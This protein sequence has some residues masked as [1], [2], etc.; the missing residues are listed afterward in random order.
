LLRISKV[1]DWTSTNTK[2]GS[3]LRCTFLHGTVATP[4]PS[5]WHYAAPWLR[6]RGRKVLT[7]KVRAR[8]QRALVGVDVGTRGRWLRRGNEAARCSGVATSWGDAAARPTMVARRPGH[9]LTGSTVEDWLRQLEGWRDVA[10]QRRGGGW[11]V[12]GCV[13]QR[14]NDHPAA[15]ACSAPGGMVPEP[16]QRQRHGGCCLAGVG[17][18]P[19]HRRLERKSITPHVIETLIK[20]INK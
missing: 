20:V 18:W 6:K 17:A 4:W 2:T 11:W 19:Q 14:G 12:V 13:A 8:R 10:S 9:G 16:R 15:V 5:T 7:S 1:F 3:L